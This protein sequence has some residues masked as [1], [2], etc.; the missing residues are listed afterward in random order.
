MHQEKAKRDRK[1]ASWF[2]VRRL[3]EVLLQRR[4]VGQREARGIG[5]QHAMSQP[6]IGIGQGAGQQQL[7]RGVGQQALEELQRQP[8]AG[9]AVG[10]AAEGETGQVRQRIESDIAMQDLQKKQSQRDDRR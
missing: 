7:S 5:D 4:C 8:L 10:R 9:H 1:A 6:A 3:A 2:L